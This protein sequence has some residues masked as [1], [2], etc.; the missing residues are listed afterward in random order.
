[1]PRILYGVSPIGLGHASRAVAVGRELLSRG[2]EVIFATGGRASAFLS[3]YGFEVRDIVRGPNPTVW[4]GRNVLPSFWYLSYWRDYR[5]TKSRVAGLMREVRPDL[6][7]GDEEFSSLSLAM[8]EEIPSVMISDEL[9][10]AF[11]GGA[12]SKAIEARVSEWY[13]RLQSSVTM[14]LVPDWGQDEGNLRHVG[15]IVR[16]VTL[17]RNETREAHGLPIDRDLVL[18]SCSG[19]GIGSF[20]VR[21]VVDLALGGGLKETVVAVA[22]GMPRSIQGRVRY[23][24]FVRDAQ[25]LVAAADVVVSL[26]GKSTIDEAMASGTPI[27][28]IP[29]RDHFEQERNARALGF[30]PGDLARV[31]ELVLGRLGRRERPIPSNGAS[32]AASAIL[33]AR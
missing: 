11:S 18:V 10:L 14:L 7:V 6:V 5:A 8:E 28:A 1:L 30:V 20:L 2:N 17:G 25:N 22:G 31:G 33:G 24:G 27:V 29:I 15:P 16:G 21:A 13:R 4:G 12:V 19:S 26:A 32:M 9:E 3:S 23:L